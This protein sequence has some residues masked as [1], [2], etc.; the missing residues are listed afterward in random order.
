[1]AVGGGMIWIIRIIAGAIL[2]REAMGFG[3]VTL[4]AM[5]GAFIG[6][7]PVLIVFFLA[8]FAG[9]ILG[10]LQWLVIRDNVIPYGPFLAFGALLV[11]V[12]WAAIWS[13]AHGMFE[14]QWLVPSAIAFCLP[15]MVLLLVGLRMLRGRVEG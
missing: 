10:V 4:M 14:I 15:V 1:M 13:Y 3:D 12:F 8:P 7:Q 9:V 11:L 6:W 2:K 5:I